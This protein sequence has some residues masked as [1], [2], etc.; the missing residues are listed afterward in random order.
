[1]KAIAI[2][3]VTALALTTFNQ[4][5]SEPLLEKFFSA[6]TPADAEAMAAQ[7]ES[8]DP[9]V[10]YRRLQQ[11]RTYLDLSLIHI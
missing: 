6:E 3:L 4:K 11:G 5:P 8:F 2:A 10:L 9:D 1:M 7:F